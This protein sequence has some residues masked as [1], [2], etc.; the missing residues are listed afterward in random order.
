[1]PGHEV[2]VCFQHLTPRNKQLVNLST[3]FPLSP[4][5]VRS[6]QFVLWAFVYRLGRSHASRKPLS[7]PGSAEVNSRQLDQPSPHQ[8][9]HRVSIHAQS[10]ALSR[11][12][13][14]QD[15][16]LENTHPKISDRRSV[17]DKSVHQGNLSP[18]RETHSPGPHSP[19]SYCSTSRSHTPD[20]PAASPR[21]PGV[22]GGSPQR[23]SPPN[24]A[25][26]PRP[27]LLNLPHHA[28]VQA[29]GQFGFQN[30]F[31][32][33]GLYGYSAGQGQVSPHHLPS[34]LSGSAFHHPA[35]QALKLAQLH[36]I[37]YAE[38]LARTGMYVSRM[39]D[40]TGGCGAQAAAMG[41]TRRPRTAFTSQ[42]LLELERQFKMNKYLS[43]PKRFEVATSLMLTETQVKIWFQN[44]RMKWKRSKKSST[45]CKSRSEDSSNPNLGSS[46][47]SKPSQVADE[48][49]ETSEDKEDIGNENIDVTE[50][51]Y[52]EDDGPE[53]MYRPLPGNEQ[54][55]LQN[56]QFM[57]NSEG[58]NMIEAMH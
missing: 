43:R 21:G 35:D 27:G 5:L 48:S 23:C 11:S 8:T 29:A 41:K 24:N 42:Q 20:S 2:H 3:S 56:L 16:T 37:N 17:S 53:D 28:M 57:K 47:G 22:R 51:D 55:V 7:S 40:Y 12:Q 32:N 46:H 50:L 1:M 9:G 38:W 4:H 39:V 6:G 31:P 18:S 44:R 58:L 25:F 36:G 19:N 52:D 45:D 14:Q 33:S 26:I 10:P 49:M 30:V 13:F 15:K 34:M 54:E